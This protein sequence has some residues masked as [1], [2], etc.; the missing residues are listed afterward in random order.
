MLRQ[1]MQASDHILLQATWADWFAR[2]FIFQL[3]SSAD[4]FEAL[5][6]TRATLERTILRIDDAVLLHRPMTRQQTRRV[7]VA[8]QRTAAASLPRAT[9]LNLEMRIRHKLGRWAVPQLPRVRVANCLAFLQA[10]RGRVPP[11]VWAATWRTLWNGWASSRRTQ[12]R[13]G[14]AGCMFRCSPAAADSIEHYAH[15]PVLHE[16][17]DAVLRLPRPESPGDRLAAFL[18]LDYR[19]GHDPEKAVKVSIRA[20][21]AYRTHC[22]CRHG[23]VSRGPAALEALG[24]SFREA[25]RGHRAATRIYDA[26]HGWS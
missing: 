20:A 1:A 5:G 7:Q 13:I 16:A 24:Q 14:L 18:G 9:T 21:A 15:C 4:H 23:R 26:A 22:L 8:F 19:A 25:V 2:S 12:G 11:R 6:V 17:A 10:L 3:D